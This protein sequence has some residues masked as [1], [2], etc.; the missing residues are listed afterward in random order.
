MNLSTTSLMLAAACL[1]AGSTHAASI[2]SSDFDAHGSTDGA[3]S[4]TGISWSTNGVSDPGSTIAL[5]TGATVQQDG[6]TQNADRLSV[7]RN[8]DTA[9]PWTIDITFMA[10]AD[11][12]TLEDLT[13]DYQFTSGGGVN[14]VA[15]HPDSGIFDVSILDGSLATLSTVQIGPLGTA[16]VASNIGTGIVADFADVALTNGSTYTLRFTASSN[17]SSGN[18]VA[19]DNFSL[20]GTVPEPGSLALLGLGGLA[21]LRRRRG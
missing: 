4:F 6:A 20:N 17:A 10:T 11:G 3:T 14:Q 19:V 15:A 16:D 9:G 5:S 8:I 7:A 1:A 13:F 21:M 12:V 2:L 18:N